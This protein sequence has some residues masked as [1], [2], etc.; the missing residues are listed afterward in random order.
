MY[1]DELRKKNCFRWPVTQD[2]LSYS[3]HDILCHLS[4]PVPLNHRGDFTFSE[5][6]FKKACEIMPKLH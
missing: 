2:V 3:Y 5:E 1:G 4:A 6:D